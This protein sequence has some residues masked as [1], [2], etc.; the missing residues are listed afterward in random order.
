MIRLA[1][2]H[3]STHLCTS[4]SPQRIR[5]HGEARHRRPR[6]IADDSVHRTPRHRRPGVLPPHP[7]QPRLHRVLNHSAVRA[8]RRGEEG[9]AVDGAE[10]VVVADVAVLRAGEEVRHAEGGGERVGRLGVGDGADGFDCVGAGVGDCC[11]DFE[12]SFESG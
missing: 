2:E 10:D 9:L 11:E 7:Q 5:V 1:N 4:E 3:D 6:R 8:L 12:A